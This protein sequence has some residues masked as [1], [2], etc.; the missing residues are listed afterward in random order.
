MVNEGYR[1][2][3]AGLTWIRG[4]SLLKQAVC[5]QPGVKA[6]GIG[7][8]SGPLSHVAAAFPRAAAMPICVGEL[9]SERYIAQV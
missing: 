6:I 3:N 1:A 2:R 8:A 5:P 4:K 9:L 7:E